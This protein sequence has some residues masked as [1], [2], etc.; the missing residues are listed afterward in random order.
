[1]QE[2][3]WAQVW[4]TTGLLWFLLAIAFAPTNKI[5]QQGLVAFL[6][7]PTL[8]LAWPARQRFVEL[9][10]GQRLVCLAVMGLGVWAMITLLWTQDPDPSRG[11]KRALYIIVFLLF[12]PILANARPE[13]VIRILQWGGLGLAVTAWLAGIEF[14]GVYGT[15]WLAG[16]VGLGA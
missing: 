14:A 13:R 9:W 12:F 15:I 3:R 11:A 16:P 10:R 7:L 8:L 4:M 1:M 2:T 6:W 5:Y